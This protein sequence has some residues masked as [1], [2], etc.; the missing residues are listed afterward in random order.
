MESNTN[1]ISRILTAV[2]VIMMFK[3]IVNYIV[4]QTVDE[5]SRIKKS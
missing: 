2:A 5:Y 3:T 1:V 4:T